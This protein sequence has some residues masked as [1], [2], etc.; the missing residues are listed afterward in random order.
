MTCKP[1]GNPLELKP[2]GMEI[3]GK[4][5]KFTVTVNIS[6]RYIVIGSVIFSFNA[7]ASDGVDGI[8]IASTS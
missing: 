7:N 8:K 1:S 5:A 3:A 6:F 2:A 4:P